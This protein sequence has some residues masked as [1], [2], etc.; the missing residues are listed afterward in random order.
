MI[1]SRAALRSVI[2]ALLFLAG[3]VAGTANALAQSATP[4]PDKID[5]LLEL[6]SDPDVKTWLA[7]QGDQGGDAAAG[8]MPAAVRARWR[9]PASHRRS[10]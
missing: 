9:R 3:L 7:A 6:L 8:R 2:V 5:R 1:F 10:T 4:P